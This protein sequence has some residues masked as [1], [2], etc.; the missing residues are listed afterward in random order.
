MPDGRSLLAN[1]MTAT[2]RCASGRGHSRGRG[3]GR[4]R[5]HSRRGLE[6]GLCRRAVVCHGNYHAVLGL[7]CALLHKGVKAHTKASIITKRPDDINGVPEER[8]AFCSAGQVKAR[9]RMRRA[10]P[11]RIGRRRDEA[12]M[13]G[14]KP[15]VHQEW[16]LGNDRAVGDAVS[17]VIPTSDCSN[18]TVAMMRNSALATVYGDDA[19]SRA[20]PRPNESQGS[21]SH[22]VSYINF[23]GSCIETRKITQDL[24]GT[25]PSQSQSSPLPRDINVRAV[26]SVRL[27][28]ELTT[29]SGLYPV[30]CA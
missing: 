24:S 22:D 14:T 2:V 6:V 3:R 20:S 15:K 27:P 8:V 7:Q 17:G 30:A 23:S 28:R 4:G 21:A 16:P 9:R 13:P 18:A 19:L 10:V 11:E 26:L 1:T 29:I 5:G 25:S 12:A